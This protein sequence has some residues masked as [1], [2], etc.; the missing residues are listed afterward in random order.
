MLRKYG[1]VIDRAFNMSYGRYD[2][3]QWM[4]II[5]MHV[6]HIHV[7]RYAWYTFDTFVTNRWKTTQYLVVV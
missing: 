4:E 2:I 5:E 7:Y 3:P 6:Y 1:E